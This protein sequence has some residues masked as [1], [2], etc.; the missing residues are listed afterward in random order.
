MKTITVRA[1]PDLDDCLQGA[2]DAYLAEHPETAA[3]QVEAAWAD[4]DDDELREEITL[5]VSA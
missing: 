3:W 4:D 5:T 1:N 2:I